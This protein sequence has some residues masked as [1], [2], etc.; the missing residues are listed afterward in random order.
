MGTQVDRHFACRVVSLKSEIH[1]ES[2]SLSNGLFV[3]VVHK[4]VGITT[5]SS[6]FQGNDQIWQNW[7]L[8]KFCPNIQCLPLFEII[9]SDKDVQFFFEKDHNLL[10]YLVLVLNRTEGKL[11]LFLDLCLSISWILDTF[12]SNLLMFF[13]AVNFW[14]VDVFISA[15]W[16]LLGV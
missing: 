14:L 1:V 16:H 12:N 6:D 5:K 2:F 9:C 7:K 13:D 15:G 3:T 4:P 8:F 10:K 11:C